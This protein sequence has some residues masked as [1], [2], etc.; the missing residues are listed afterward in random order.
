MLNRAPEMTSPLQRGPPTTAGGRAGSGAEPPGTRRFNGVP[1]RQQGEGYNENLLR[2]DWSASTGSLH[3]SREGSPAFAQGRPM[4]RVAS[5]G[6]PHDSRGKEARCALGQPGRRASTGSPH[7]S[8]GKARAPLAPTACIGGFNGVPPRQ[9]GEGP[10]WTHSHA[11]SSGFNGVPPRQQG[12]GRIAGALSLTSSSQLQRGP[13]TTA[14]GRAGD[15]ALDDQELVRAS[16]GS[17]HDSRGK[18]PRGRD[19]Q[20]LPHDAST[21]SPHDS[22]GKAP[23]VKSDTARASTL[24]R[25][26]PTT[27]GGRWR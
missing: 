24:Q 6:S 5:T 18:V 8:R 12:E 2:M 7:D 14:G 25:C 20:P 4:A 19:G 9:Q 11:A 13:P 10:F 1:P 22:R 21:G 15:D 16:T 23:P 27:A 3:D 26:P 17:P